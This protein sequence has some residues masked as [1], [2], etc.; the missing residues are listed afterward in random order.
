MNAL[1]IQKVTRQ[2]ERY[3]R[4]VRVMG[5][6]SAVCSC[7]F[8]KIAVCLPQQ[9]TGVTLVYSLLLLLLS[10]K[11]FKNVKCDKKG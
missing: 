3:E 5:L 6:V 1:F 2:N 8:H 7:K 4:K 9:L 11:S 10:L